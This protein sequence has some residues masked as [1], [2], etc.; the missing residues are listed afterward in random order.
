MFAL[1]SFG[2]IYVA[3]GIFWGFFTGTQEWHWSVALIGNLVMCPFMFSVINV[4]V[5]N[6]T[7]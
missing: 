5:D 4:L 2:V 1:I 6:I 3:L 7:K